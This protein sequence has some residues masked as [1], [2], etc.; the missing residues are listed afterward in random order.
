M[1]LSEFAVV[2]ALSIAMGKACLAVTGAGVSINVGSQAYSDC[3]P[4]ERNIAVANATGML[5]VQLELPPYEVRGITMSAPGRMFI[6]AGTWNQGAYTVVP[7]LAQRLNI[8]PFV[9]WHPMPGGITAAAIQSWH[10]TGQEVGGNVVGKYWTFSFDIPPEL[11]DHQLLFSISYVSE[12]GDTLISLDPVRAEPAHR[13]HALTVVSPCSE[14]DRDRALGSHVVIAEQEG[15]H[16]LAMFLAD[17]LLETGWCDL[18]GIEAA[19]QA[20]GYMK[21]RER[22]VEYR[23]MNLSAHGKTTV[24]GSMIY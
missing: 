15:K 14:D 10:S 18:A 17:S 24:Y 20:A 4:G 1:F 5:H 8:R 2:C 7:G 3:R 23:N 19:M 22:Y 11:A 21:L 12:F 6:Q 16:G 9:W 13:N